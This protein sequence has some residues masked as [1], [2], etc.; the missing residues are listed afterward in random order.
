M[1]LQKFSSFL[2]VLVFLTSGLVTSGCLED[3]ETDDEVEQDDN[4]NNYQNDNS[5]NTNQ[6]DNS[7]S[8]YKDSDN[9]GYADS[10]DEF[11]YDPDEWKDSDSDGV[12]DNAD[13][14][15][16]DRCATDDMDHDGKPDSIKE[17]CNTSLIVDDDT[18]GDGFNNTIEQQLG[19]NPNNPASKPLDY[20]S[21]GVPDGLDDDID[22][23][24]M[25]NT[26][27]QCPRGSVNWE[28]G[29]PDED[30]DMDGC[31]DDGVNDDD[32]NFSVH[33]FDSYDS[34]TWTGP[35]FMHYMMGD[36]NWRH[37]V[38]DNHTM[39]TESCSG[40]A[41]CDCSPIPASGKAADVPGTSSKC[42]GLVE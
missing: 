21:D 6:N 26:V 23:D 4:S 19:T 37:A 9:D 33:S 31:K 41:S 7:G 13:E 32:D 25:N 18:D 42:I 10:S 16:N 11:P 27:D 29:N 2:L 20:D 39:C 35:Q 30:W 1:E 22:N 34:S 36:N 24:G 5:G 15:P 3:I 8:T 14:F 12:G 17:N 28:A 38:E 40:T